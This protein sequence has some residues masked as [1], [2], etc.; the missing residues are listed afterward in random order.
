MRVSDMV[1]VA[2]LG[3]M[4]VYVANPR[5]LEAEAGLKPDFI[6]LDLI[7]SFDYIASHEKLGDIVT[8]S[9]GRFENDASNGANVGE[10]HNLENEIEEKLIKNLAE[11]IA[12][13]VQ[14]H[15]PPRV[16]LAL[17]EPIAKRVK[18]ELDKLSSK[19]IDLNKS[20]Y[21]C[22]D[23]DL[24]KTDKMKLIDFFREKA[25]EC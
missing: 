8:D 1:I 6:K 21:R 14:K 11:D 10:E 9:S 20:L 13:S 7:D 19:Y 3:E 18:D 5:D 23:E 12:K 17:P 24:V 2:N 16:F 15:N 25:K 22:L 4:K